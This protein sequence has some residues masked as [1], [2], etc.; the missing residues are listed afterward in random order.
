MNR[1]EFRVNRL[2]LPSGGIRP[3][4]IL[5][6]TSVDAEL[7]SKST[8]A[9]YWLAGFIQGWKIDVL[10]DATA[11]LFFRLPAWPGGGAGAVVFHLQP[12][13]ERSRGR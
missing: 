13:A 6:L 7:R 12:A 2:H 4:I 11:G 10:S 1:D 8:P 3:A 9:W 5:T